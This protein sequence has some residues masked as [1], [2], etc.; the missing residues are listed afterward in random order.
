MG[1]KLTNES[2]NS[3]ID[4]IE[5]LAGDP[6]E[7]LRRLEGTGDDRRREERKDQKRGDQNLNGDGHILQSLLPA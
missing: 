4:V 6:D 7:R 3:L 2:E 1:A 5:I